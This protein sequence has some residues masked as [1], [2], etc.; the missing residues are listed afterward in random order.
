MEDEENS[1]IDR[2]TDNEDVDQG[3]VELHEVFSRFKDDPNDDFIN[4]NRLTQVLQALGRNP[5]LKDS[6]QR[7]NELEADAEESWTVIN[8]DPNGLRQALEKFDSTQEGYIDID[9]FRTIMTTLGEPLIDEEL[10]DLIQLGLNEE[11]TKINI[12]YLL[13]QLLGNNT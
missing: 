2:N 11:Q 12:N 4:I 10:D 7:I 8:N 6:E 13:D 5:S 1:Q 9:K 3:M